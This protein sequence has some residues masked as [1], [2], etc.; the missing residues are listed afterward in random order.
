MGKGLRGALSVMTGCSLPDKIRAIAPV[1][2]QIPSATSMLVMRS[3][4]FLEALN[5]EGI[6]A[7]S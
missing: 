5:K 2:A 1:T 6:K 4:N 3:G 7:R